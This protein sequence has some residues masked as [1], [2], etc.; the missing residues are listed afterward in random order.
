MMAPVALAPAAYSKVINLT[1]Q[2]EGATQ[3]S[4]MNLQMNND[5]L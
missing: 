1:E 3:V 5:R 4:L 2:H